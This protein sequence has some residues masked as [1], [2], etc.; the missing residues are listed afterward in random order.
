LT[1]DDG[2]VVDDHLRTSAPDVYAAGDVASAY[3]PRLRRRIRVEHWDNAISQGSVAGA[4]LA[5]DDVTHD[6]M[7]YFFS[8]QYDWGLEYLGHADPSACDEVVV[9]GSLDKAF[10][11]FWVADGHVAAAIHV[12]DWDAMDPIRRM[13]GRA[14]DP[15]LGD[16]SVPLEDVARAVETA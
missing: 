11:V 7:P 5:G 2:A 8:D 16:E 12:N 3:V 4:N 6:R 9:R 14:A 15:R 10:T 1:V 13:V